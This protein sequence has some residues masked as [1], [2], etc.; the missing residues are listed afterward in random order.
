MIRYIDEPC[1]VILSVKVAQLDGVRIVKLSLCSRDNNVTRFGW[2][3]L[4]AYKREMNKSIETEKKRS[5]IH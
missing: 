2:R 1:V 4:D 3:I 5:P